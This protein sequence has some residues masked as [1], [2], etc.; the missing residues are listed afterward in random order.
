M[1]RRAAAPAELVKAAV[2]AHEAGSNWPGPGIPVD[3]SGVAV[4]QRALELAERDYAVKREE[5]ELKRKAKQGE[6]EAARLELANL[7]LEREQAVI[8][9]R[10]TASSRPAT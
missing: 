1:E 7:E 10:S 9:P 6:V 3:E 4:A 2:K 5:L 8:R